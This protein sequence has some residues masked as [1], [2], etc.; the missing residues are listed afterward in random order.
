VAAW[1]RLEDGVER[2]RV[3]R[4]SRVSAGAAQVARV[5]DGAHGEESGD[6]ACDGEGRRG[7]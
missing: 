3:E 7:L 1:F 5:D 4:W 6:R 2:H